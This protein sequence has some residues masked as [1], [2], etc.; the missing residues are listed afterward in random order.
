MAVT[1]QRLLILI[2]AQLQARANA[3]AVAADP[4]TTAAGTFSVPLRLASDTGPAPATVG[5][6]TSWAMTDA[7]RTRLVGEFGV[8]PIPLGGTVDPTAS[9]WLFEAGDGQWTPDAALAVVGWARMPSSPD[10]E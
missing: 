2:R 6:W 4:T 9:F 3:I 1:T 5:Y 7:Q 8:T 10:G